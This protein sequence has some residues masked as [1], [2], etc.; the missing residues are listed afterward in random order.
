MI[1]P[2]FFCNFALQGKKGE[3]RKGLFRKR[4]RKEELENVLFSCGGEREA[5]E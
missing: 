1:S 4:R 3:G 5:A 2:P